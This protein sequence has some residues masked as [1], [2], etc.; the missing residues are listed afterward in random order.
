MNTIGNILWFIICG[1]WLG[2]GWF[3]VG[4]VWCIT[5]IGIPIGLQCFKLGMLSLLPFGKDIQYSEKI[6][7]F[8]LNVLWIIFGGIFLAIEAIVIGAILCVTII[9]IPFG[10]QCFKIAKLA[11]LPFGANIINVKQY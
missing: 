1:L 8:F 5:I 10:I 7:S 2:I 11:L 9:G 4:F 6:S 3:L